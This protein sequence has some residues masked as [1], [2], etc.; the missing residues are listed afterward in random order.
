MNS[1]MFSKRHTLN[2]QHCRKLLQ[3]S[4]AHTNTIRCCVIASYTMQ[5]LHLLK[6]WLERRMSCCV[7]GG[8]ESMHPLNLTFGAK[9]IAI[10]SCRR[11]TL[12]EGKT[13]SVH[14]SDLF[15]PSFRQRQSYFNLWVFHELTEAAAHS[16]KSPEQG[17]L[18][19]YFKHNNNIAS[20]SILKYVM[21]IYK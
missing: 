2:R 13:I 16:H 21:N 12:H 20:I 9:T 10:D 3:N 4:L 1:N 14:N 15:I 18:D 19:R 7:L 17:S 6:V 5:M 11:I 8:I